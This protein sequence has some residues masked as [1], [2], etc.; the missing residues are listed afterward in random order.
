MDASQELDRLKK[1]IEDLKREMAGQTR[2]ENWLKIAAALGASVAF[3]VGVIQYISNN[4][5]EFRKAIWKEQYALYQEACASAAAIANANR[6]ED[7]KDQRESFWRLYWGRLS[8]LE[9]PNVKHAMMNYGSEL[10]KVENG[11]QPPS[12]LQSS[13]YSLARACRESLRQTWNPTDLGDVTETK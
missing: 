8:I 5:N 11:K 10:K 3:V 1:Q 7:V 6:L 4:N 12:A 9:H 2:F 13:S